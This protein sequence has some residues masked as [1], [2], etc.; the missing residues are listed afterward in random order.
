M[1]DALTYL[2]PD[3]LWRLE[4]HLEVENGGQPI[5]TAVIGNQIW[6]MKQMSGF[7]WD[8]N[9]FDE[10]FVYQSITENVFQNPNSFKIFASKSWSGANGAIVWCPRFIDPTSTPIVTTDSSFRIYS[11]CKN[12]QVSTLG[13]P[14]FTRYA[15][16][17][18]SPGG[19]FGSVTIDC[20]QVDYQ[21]NPGL[22]VLE[23]HIYGK[24]FGLVSWQTFNLVNGQYVQQKQ[25]L[26]NTMVAAPNPKP[27]FPCGVPTI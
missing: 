16:T 13:G 15:L 11:D 22:T 12:F 24:A 27:Q 19:S 1:I 26:F 25:T 8:M 23:R 4:N 21:W 14:I 10:K 20:L 9:T 5:P 6:Y 18:F 7:P 2:L 17:K 3:E